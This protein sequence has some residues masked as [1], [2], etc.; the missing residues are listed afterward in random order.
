MA[1]RYETQVMQLMAPFPGRQFKMAQLVRYAGVVINAKDETVRMGVR[2]AVLELVQRGVVEEIRPD[3][4]R[5]GQSFAY[6]WRK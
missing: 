1:D 2:R 4:Y 5:P 3:N 6:A